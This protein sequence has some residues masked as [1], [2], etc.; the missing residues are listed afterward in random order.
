M[1]GQTAV[2]AH[3]KSCLVIDD[4]SIVRKVERRIVEN[5][6]FR[7]A[8][9]EHGQEALDYCQHKGMPDAILL[10]CTLPDVPS[11]ELLG[12]IR[13]LPDGAKPFI[14]Y[15]ASENDTKD[16]T[17]AISSGASDFIL[18]PF[19]REELLARFAAAGIA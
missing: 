8:E 17:R 10:D 19:T 13:A 4:S 12:Q 11:N 18:K 5:L 16:I 15:C 3:M 6:E 9:A 1:H 14:L 7:V 2:G